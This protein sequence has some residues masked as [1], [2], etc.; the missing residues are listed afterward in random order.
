MSK[1]K[2]ERRSTPVAQEVDSEVVAFRQLFEDRSLLDE[3]VRENARRMLQEA[4][5]AQA[6]VFHRFT[7]PSCE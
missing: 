2:T 7:P 4:I 3:L 6:R 1:T 5:N